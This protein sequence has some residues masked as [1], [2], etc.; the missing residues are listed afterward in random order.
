MRGWIPK[1]RQEWV[2]LGITLPIVIGVLV[3]I[4]ITVSPAASVLPTVLAGALLGFAL[5]RGRNLLLVWVRKR[6]QAPRS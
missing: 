2:V 1:D 5:A 6:D 3:L 4:R